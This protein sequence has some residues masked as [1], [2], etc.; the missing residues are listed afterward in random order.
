MR[1]NRH[2]KSLQNKPELRLFTIEQE[3]EKFQDDMMTNKLEDLLDQEE[4][5]DEEE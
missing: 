2:Q 4:E 3:S 5:L 1:L